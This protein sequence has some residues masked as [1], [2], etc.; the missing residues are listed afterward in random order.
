MDVL[1]NRMQ[2]LKQR[3]NDNAAL[4]HR[5]RFVSLMFL[6]GVGEQEYLV[7]IERG[8]VSDILPRQ[9]A[10]TSG[11][12]TI[13]AAGETWAEHWKPV[14][15]RDYHDLFSMLPKQL[16]TIDGDLLPLMQN[17]QYFKDVLASL[18]EPGECNAE[19]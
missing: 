8:R 10:T 12:F 4:V 7:A 11:Q 14:P 3:V 1:D 17:L 5:G 15:A 19:V 6:L 16:A 13:R 2:T 9:L 18:R